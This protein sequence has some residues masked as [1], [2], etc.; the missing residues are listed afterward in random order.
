MGTSLG[1]TVMKALPIGIPKLIISTLAYSPMIRPDHACGDLMMMQ[2]VGGFWGLNSLSKDVLWKGAEAIV[3][4][5]NA[6]AAK[7]DDEDERLLRVGVTSLGIRACRYMNYLKPLLDGYGYELV[8]FH[9]DGMGGRVFEQAV[10]EGLIDAALDLSA[11]ELGNQVC[12]GQCSA[13]T[14]RYEAA[15]KRGIPQVVAPG[16]IDTFAVPTDKGIPEAFRGRFKHL[17]NSLMMVIGSI[18][19]ER[20][21]VGRVM[22]RKLNRSKGPTAIVIPMQ[23]FS[24]EDRAGG[25]WHCP[26][27][28]AAFMK[29]LKG[30]I[31]QGIEV[32]KLDCHINDPLFAETAASLLKRMIDRGPEKRIPG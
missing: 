17:H 26:D 16:G 28:S 13:G 29:G 2:W 8:A 6:Y 3:G 19:S 1:L 7:G 25:L 18:E 23:G 21:E 12:G 30:S 32:V 20:E 31:R 24:S 9:T 4:A 14:H 11:F 15:A 22:A 27:G 10:S 5:A